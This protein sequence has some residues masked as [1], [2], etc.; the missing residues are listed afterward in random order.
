M[1]IVK[2]KKLN[3]KGIIAHFMVL[4]TFFLSP[5]TVFAQDDATPSVRDLVREKVKEKLDSIIKKPMAVVG[6]LSQITDKTLEIKTAMDQKTALVATGEDTKFFQITKGK[7]K[8]AKAEDLA[9][10]QN[11]LAL[12]YKN[13]KG[14]LE[15]RRLI[16]SDV[17]L[18][19]NK[20]QTAYGVVT[21]LGKSTVAVKHPTK[22]EE[23]SIK[24][25]STTKIT[26]KEDGGKIATLSFPD[27]NV[28]DRLVAIGP[29][30][31]SGLL[32]ATR[33]H[34]IPG[35]AKGLDRKLSPTP[36]AK[37]PTVTPTPNPA[38]Q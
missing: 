4:L 6:T 18:L 8:E 7:R 17:P 32:I 31:E 20:K 37:K 34:L 36:T 3:V 22:A 38:S 26:G 12:G 25:S 10:G 27:I 30:N 21:L 19:E 11:I 9:L 5:L 23:R 13:D 28:G 1:R 14:V 35:E 29:S 24:V 15:A 16:I 33:I 2:R